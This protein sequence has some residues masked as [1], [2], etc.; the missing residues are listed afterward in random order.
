MC[1]L[2]G[3]EGEVT[4]VAFSHD[5]AQVIS[6]SDVD[7]TVRFFDVASG[8]QVRQ[9]AGEK[10]A[11]VE[12]LSGEQKRRHVIVASGDCH[13]LRIYECAEEQQ[14]AE[15]DVVAAPVAFFKAPQ[16]IISVRCFGA[17]ICVGCYEG[18]VCILSAPFLT[19]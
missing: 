17:A 19:A 1:T 4:R 3:H 2:T 18:A 11:L 10:F 7:I 13:T 15:D 5:G 12:G 16:Q 6:A 9:L 8:R 14:H